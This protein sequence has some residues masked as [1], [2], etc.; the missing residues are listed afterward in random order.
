MNNHMY[1]WDW[2]DTE[3][4]RCTGAGGVGCTQVTGVNLGRVTECRAAGFEVADMRLGAMTDVVDQ[5]GL[6]I[7]H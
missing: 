1:H 7:M 4:L 3:V 2:L 6:K 5:Q